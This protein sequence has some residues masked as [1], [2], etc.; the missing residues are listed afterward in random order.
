MSIADRIAV[1]RAGKLAQ[2]GTPDELYHRPAS[3][4]V[5][6]FIGNTNLIRGEV[7]EQIGREVRVRTGMG[8]IVAMAGDGAAVN[9]RE[10]TLSVRPEQVEI[11]EGAERA[12]R[13][14]VTGR[15]VESS[16]L[17]ESSEHVIEVNGVKVRAIAVPPRFNLHGEVGVEFDCSDVVVLES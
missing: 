11:V 9:T 6:E 4:F 12:G 2:V 13:N 10:V 8:E 3:A 7:I 17:G 15:V 14:R 16:F 5:A 1:M